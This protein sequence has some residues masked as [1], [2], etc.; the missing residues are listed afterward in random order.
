MTEPLRR[1]QDLR[2]APV[3]LAGDRG[4][5]AVRLLAAAATAT[6]VGVIA[7]FLLFGTVLADAGTTTPSCRRSV[8]DA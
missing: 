8:R 5:A 6:V 4:A 3:P 7:V 1:R 2:T